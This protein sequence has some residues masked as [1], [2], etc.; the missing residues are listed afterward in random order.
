MGEFAQNMPSP[1]VHALSQLTLY[2]M[3]EKAQDEL[4]KGE[5]S[6]SIPSSAISGHQ[7]T[8]AG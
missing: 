3:Q 1:I 8:F 4:S 7:S 6:K 5:Y 2:R